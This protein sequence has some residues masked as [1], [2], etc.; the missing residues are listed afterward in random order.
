MT[1][2]KNRKDFIIWINKQIEYYKPILG[3]DLIDI[4]VE[5]KESTDFLE[6]NNV[7]PYHDTMLWF[8]QKAK[9]R[10]VEGR[11]DKSV[12]LHELCHII[13]DPLYDKGFKRFVTDDELGE[14]RERLT[15]RMSLIIRNLDKK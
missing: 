10:W 4:D 11:I 14:E 2:A 1:T 15:D 3:I 13:T 7:Y 9:D 8:G 6:I 5:F 12:I